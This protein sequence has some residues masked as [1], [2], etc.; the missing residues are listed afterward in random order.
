M[1]KICLILS[2]LFLF[3]F[4]AQAMLSAQTPRPTA[5]VKPVPGAAPASIFVDGL[6]VLYDSSQS[7]EI[8]FLR[9]FHSDIDIQIFDQTP[10]CGYVPLTQTPKM[11]EK[12]KIEIYETNSTRRSNAFF[13]PTEPSAEDFR[14]MP[15]MC[16]A[17]WFPSVTAQPTQSE[18]L[19][20]DHLAGK[21]ILNDAVFYTESISDNRVIRTNLSTGQKP[22]RE[23]FGKVLGADII[24][25][26]GNCGVT[27]KVTGNM[28]T[29]FTQD[30][31]PA[32]GPYYILVRTHP[33]TRGNH[34]SLLFDYFI[35]LP[36]T[37]PEFNFEY[38]RRE[39]PWKPPCSISK[40]IQ[41]QRL[42]K[43]PHLREGHGRATEF[44]CQTFGSCGG[45]FPDP[46]V[47]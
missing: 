19:V 18:Q 23:K 17:K 39:N 43:N 31:N 4:A 37:Q 42:R 21:L 41:K 2:V 10:Q 34:F 7:T 40:R 29:A 25:Q 22:P 13:Q 35:A 6:S 20:K 5:T 15:D 1:K 14:F 11:G 24:C 27:V 28:G 45:T 33:L 47:P 8:G 9:D 38:E 44:A 32:N 12:L 46:S 36:S 26:T 30:L 3:L 16:S